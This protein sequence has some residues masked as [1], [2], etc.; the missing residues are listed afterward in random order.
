M[1]SFEPKKRREESRGLW[2]GVLGVGPAA[3]NTGDKIGN[4]SILVRKKKET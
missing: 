2:L 4:K 3:R 1:K